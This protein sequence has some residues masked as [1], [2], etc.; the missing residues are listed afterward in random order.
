MK[1]FEK[2]WPLPPDANIE[3]S[4][5]P[6]S[7]SVWG[8]S[9]CS[10]GDQ[11]ISFSVH[12]AGLFVYLDSGR[13]GVRSEKYSSVFHSKSALYV[14]PRTPYI[15]HNLGAG[16]T[17]WFVSL[18]EFLCKALPENIVGLDALDLL[19]AL[20]RKIASWGRIEAHRGS[21]QAYVTA[22]LQELNETKTSLPTALRL[23]QSAQL[24]SIAEKLVAC[25]GDMNN[26]TYWAKQAGMSRRSF[27]RAYSIETGLP[28]S[29]WRRRLKIHAAIKSL[30]AGMSVGDISFDLGYQNP[31]AF[32]VAFRNEFGSSPTEFMKKHA[33]IPHRPGRKTG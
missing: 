16:P 14:P 32:I 30:G 4:S 23:P 6:Y 9:L 5:V 11:K 10:P 18:P 2:L 21:Q 26:I 13:F 17:G 12:E 7:N 33:L 24:L 25:P 22:F 31:S 15:V 29:T 20:G 3:I 27:T 8:H 19:I 1:R 28:F